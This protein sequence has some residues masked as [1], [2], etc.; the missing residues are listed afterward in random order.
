MTRNL[1]I[2]WALCWESD[3]TLELKLYVT[4][5]NFYIHSVKDAL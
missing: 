1:V 3:F 2:F 4:F 5:R